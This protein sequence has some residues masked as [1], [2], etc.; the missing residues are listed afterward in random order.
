MFDI[1]VYLHILKFSSFLTFMEKNAL[2]PPHAMHRIYPKPWK[3]T[4]GFSPI[5]LDNT[6]NSAISIIVQIM[7]LHHIKSM[8]PKHTYGVEL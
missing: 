2:M 3:C 8:Y 5:Y 4:F 7:S 6:L 1:H